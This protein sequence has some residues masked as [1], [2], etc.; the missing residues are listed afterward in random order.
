MSDLSKYDETIIHFFKNHLLQYLTNISLINIGQPDNS[1]KIIV[2]GFK[3]MLHVLSIIYTIQMP[4]QQINSYLE[5]C[6]LLFIE[7]TEQVYLKK[8]DSVHTPDM[9][10]Y[11]VL[12]GNLTLDQHNST[13]SPFITYLY[14]WSHIIPFWENSQLINDQREY[15]VANFMESYML[16]FFNND[17]HHLYRI[18]E[19]IQNTIKDDANVFN[20][21]TL[22]LTSFINYFS[23]KTVSFTK[24]NIQQ[25]CFDKFMREQDEYEKHI[26]NIESIKNSDVMIKWIFE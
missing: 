11:N 2:Q 6:P 26:S 15:L 17:K 7:Y 12:L 14:K 4:E 10:V 25:I 1:H 3:T 19:I 16:I 9:F 8:T 5:K 13:N 24:E 21:Y 23:N 18:L 20:K 22:I